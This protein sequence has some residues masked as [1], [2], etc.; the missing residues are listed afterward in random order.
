MIKW[1]KVSVL[2]KTTGRASCTIKSF[3]SYSR[4]KDS[5]D[6][7][8]FPFSM[9][10]VLEMWGNALRKAGFDERDY[11]TKRRKYRIHGL[12]KFFRSQLALAVP[13][14]IVETLMGH[15]G[16]LTESYRRYSERELWEWYKK[17]EHLLLITPP[18]EFLE[19]G[20][21]VK[22]DLERNRKLLEHYVL[23]NKELRER[24]EKLEEEIKVIAD[25]VNLF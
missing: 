9:N 19:L 6:D 21:E 22:E 23:E 18:K 20:T 3:L 15:E 17:G 5:L 13:V 25:V 7:R 4:G 24:V 16:Y 11:R 1:I 12:R 10:V 8:L 2:R 14:D